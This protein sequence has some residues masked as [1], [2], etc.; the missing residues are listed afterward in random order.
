MRK[1]IIAGNWK[2][3]LGDATG[4]TALAKGMV[5]KHGSTTAVDI[6]LCPPFTSIREA[7]AA[8]SGSKIAIG[9]QNLYP[10]AGGAFTGEIS[11][12]FLKDCGCTYVILGHSE[13]RTYFKESNEFINEKVKFSFDNGLIPIMCLGETE[14]ERDAGNTEAVVE[15]HIRGGLAGLTADQVK[16]MVLAYEPVW[17]IGTGKTATPDD[18]QNVHAFARKMVASLYDDDTANTVR[19]QYGGSVKPGNAGDLLTQP[20]IDGALVGGAALKV[21]DFAGIIDNCGAL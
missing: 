12:D 13:R 16:S 9:G 21:E 1:L 20:D 17:A 6:V 18:A 10:K 8:V 7:S 11:A 14:A 15:D 19:I 2:M 5:D 3:N 4:A